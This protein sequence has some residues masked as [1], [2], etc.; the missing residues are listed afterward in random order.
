MSEEAQDKK[1]LTIPEKM[2]HAQE[3]A[4]KRL[5]QEG[6][7]VFVGRCADQILKDDNQ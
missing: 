5:A 7:C 4:V 2:F 1:R 3:E 6:P